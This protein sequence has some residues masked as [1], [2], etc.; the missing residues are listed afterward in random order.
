MRGCACVCVCW[1]IANIYI[2]RETR[3]SVIPVHRTAQKG[4][5]MVSGREGIT[6]SKHFFSGNF[7]LRI[8]ALEGYVKARLA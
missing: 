3:L 5:S 4:L 8:F 2:Y 6:K 1:V 7:L